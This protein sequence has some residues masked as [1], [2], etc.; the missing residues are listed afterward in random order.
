MPLRVG[1]R[2]GAL[3]RARI[4]RFGVPRTRG[5]RGG[6]LVPPNGGFG[7]GEDLGVP[8]GLLPIARVRGWSGITT[9]DP[10]QGRRWSVICPEPP[11]FRVRRPDL[12]YG[13]PTLAATTSGSAAPTFLDPGRS[14]G[15][16]ERVFWAIL[17]HVNAR[18]ASQVRA[19]EP[20][21]PRRA[22]QSTRSAP[23]HLSRVC[24]SG[25]NHQE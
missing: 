18:A 22:R 14:A 9:S 2:S 7:P 1:L 4:P 20:L 17:I 24:S 13:V 19:S 16:T 15:L 25:Q 3:P 6:Y 21:L 8:F 11:R 23:T 10:T 5:C 12:R